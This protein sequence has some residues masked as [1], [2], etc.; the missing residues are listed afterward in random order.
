MPDH[1]QT[2]NTPA[3]THLR[4]DR[5]PIDRPPA[6]SHHPHSNNPDPNT[7]DP[8]NPHPNTP[9]TDTPDTDNLHPHNLHTDRPLTYN[10]L[11]LNRA[12]DLRTNPAWLQTQLTR[13]DTRVI[14]LHQDQIVDTPTEPAPATNGTPTRPTSQPRPTTQPSTSTGPL[15][16]QSTVFLGLD[17][18]VPVFAT[19]LPE[20]T[21]P[22]HDLRAIVTTLDPTE[23][24]TLAYARGMLHWT[25]N[26][27]FCGTC[28]HPTRPQHGGHVRACT[29]CGKLHF[30]RIEPAVITLV[31]WH[32][33]C[34]LGR[35]HGSS[36]YSTLAGFVEPGRTSKPPYA[37]KSTKKP[38]SPSPTSTTRRPRHGPSH[39]A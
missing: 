9:D 30:P 39:P 10:A 14:R 37:G 27:R 23:A 32:D 1:N 13:P 34:L 31:T 29:N 5:P 25:R 36:G 15:D 26:Q 16:P 18:D 24:A 28:G 12:P 22:T 19:E 11:T 33:T 2:P 20:P 17:G 4:N 8:N 7:L 38:A 3:H 21:G 6:E 35:H